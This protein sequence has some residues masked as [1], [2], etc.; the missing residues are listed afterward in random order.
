VKIDTA[1]SVFEFH[2]FQVP[3]QP[4]KVFFPPET[5]ALVHGMQWKTR[6]EEMA[7]NLKG[8]VKKR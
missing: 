2:G 4:G 8:E 7:R 1:P 5:T 6:L 3:S